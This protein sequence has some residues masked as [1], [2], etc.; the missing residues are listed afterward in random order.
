MP[1]IDVLLQA[2]ARQFYE[3]IAT[4]TER[5]RLD[6]IIYLLRLDPGVDG[7]LRFTYDLEAP[8]AGGRIFYDGFF[9]LVYRML[10]NWTMSILNIGFEEEIPGA[11]RS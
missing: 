6:D 2:P 11:T 5:A 8:E 1:D 9:W 7:E 4:P 3:E 10:N